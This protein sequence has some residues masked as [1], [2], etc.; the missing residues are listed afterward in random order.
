MADRSSIEW[1]DA[2]WNVVTGCS[3][4]SRGCENC[5]AEREAARRLRNHPSR[6]GLT[7]RNGRWTGKARFNEQWL[8]RP[9]RWRKPRKIFVAASGDLFHEDIPN[10]W[11][12]RIFE[13][14]ALADIHVFQVLT[15]R[16]SRAR[17]YLAGGARDRILPKVSRCFNAHG[18]AAREWPL[19]NVWIGTSVEDQPTADER[20][21]ALRQIEA[22][23][24]WVSIEPLLGPVEIDEHL[25]DL[26]WV[27]VGGES[28]PG[29][30]SMDP[31]WARSLR[32]QC[33]CARVPFFFKQWGGI[34]SKAG[35][36][37]LDGRQWRQMPGE[38]PCAS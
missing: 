4:V 24:L 26:D 12:D 22:A 5:W 6:Q 20:L 1:T 38:G 14:M 35:G 7:D 36:C 23:V 32:N 18:M 9:L 37:E 21:A 28:G 29:A 3:R 2:T 8:D 13:V 31:S 17:K 11:L 19:S 10:H 34:T 25:G 15:K 33:I 16:P 27:V 30:R